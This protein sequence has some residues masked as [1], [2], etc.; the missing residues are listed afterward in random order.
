MRLSRALAEKQMDL[1]LRDKLI[2]EGKITKTE[3]DKYL[4]SLSD[5]T[6]NS[7]AAEDAPKEKRE[8]TH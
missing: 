8:T 5:D 1:R 7:Q 4:K 6:S 2:T 3:L